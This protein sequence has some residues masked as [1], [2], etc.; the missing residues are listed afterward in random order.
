MRGFSSSFGVLLFLGVSS[1]LG[2]CA[3]V[4]EGPSQTVKFET[5]GAHNALCYADVEG[6]KFT[7]KPPQSISLP[8]ADGDLIVK[9]DAPGNRTRT[10]V[11][12]PQHEGSVKWNA[13]NG[14]VGYGWDYASG[15]V[16]HYPETVIV[17]FRNLPVTE[18][19]LPAHNSPDIRQ[20]ETY[21]LE[22]FLPS[23]PRMNADRYKVSPEVLKREKP[24]ASGETSNETGAFSENPQK[25][26]DKGD[27]KSVI[28]SLDEPSTAPQRILPGQ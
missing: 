8:K 2:G 9:C 25:G 12:K 27:L 20:P 24:S 1:A 23:E 16:Y 6:M 4:M 17:D 3:Y 28:R 19:P 11:I 26:A 18:N 15:A 22:E 5:P 7:V 13:L 14:G 10:I 21:E